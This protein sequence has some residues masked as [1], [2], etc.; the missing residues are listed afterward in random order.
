MRRTVIYLL[1]ILFL[2]SCSERQNKTEMHCSKVNLLL[3]SA[4]IS[5]FMHHIP[6]DSLMSQKLFEFYRSRGDR[7]IWFN[8]LSS[9]EV[10]DQLRGILYRY[11]NDVADSTFNPIAIIDKISEVQDSAFVSAHNEAL[12]YERELEF[13]YAFMQT[14]N[15][16]Y[17]GNRQ[18]DTIFTFGNNRKGEI[19]SLALL[20]KFVEGNGK[21]FETLIPL[22]P[23]FFLLVKGLNRYNKNLLENNIGL[24][25]DSLLLI[26][27]M[28]GKD[29]SMIKRRLQAEDSYD[30]SDTTELFNE[31]LAKAVYDLKLKLGL[32][33]D[34][35]VDKKFTQYLQ[36]KSERRL[37]KVKLNIE[38][39]R[40]LRYMPNNNCLL[41][42]IPA[43]QLYV[44]E[45]NVQTWNMDVIVGKRSTPT[46]L[47]SDSI[48]YIVFNPYWNIPESI[49]V[50]EIMAKL[51][52][53]STYLARRGMKVVNI[54]KTGIPRI[55]QNPG[56]NNSLGKIKFMFPNKYN[57]YLHDTPSKKSFSRTQR[58]L[59][60]GCVRLYD[61]KR[62]AMF[63]LKDYPE[64]NETI[65]EKELESNRE[66]RVELKNPV[67]ISMVYFTAW[68]DEIGNINFFNDVY[69]YDESVVT[70]VKE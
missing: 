62:L 67:P 37:K 50:G 40:R 24:L 45:N 58:A 64:W 63:L 34:S 47:F 4:T 66:K 33:A 41:V 38:R 10:L 29:V 20:G 27:G 57:I 7:P 39:A 19:N 13:T 53:D 54:S 42:N 9:E 61:P 48:R 36:E 28:Q 2:A 14:V 51:E 59:S 16:I 30:L 6:L 8:N 11:S 15:R 23:Q 60:H 17:Y 31:S 26:K 46:N 1:I 5:T 52:Q 68:A 70:Q 32:K 56:A 12:V 55:I 21:E 22:H 65:I 44:F 69:K 18:L 25:G 3:D 43:F 35:V 49:V